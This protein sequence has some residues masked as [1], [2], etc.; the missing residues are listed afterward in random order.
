MSVALLLKQLLHL[1]K[2]LTMTHLIRKANIADVERI[3]SLY[4]KVGRNEG[5]LARTEPEITETYVASFVNNARESGLQLLVEKPDRSGQIIGEVHCYALGPK[6]FKHVLGELTIAIDPDFQG[7]G[8]GRLLFQNLLE[9][10]R[11]ERR[12]ILRVELI[13]RESNMKAIQFYKSLGFVAEGR[14]ENRISSKNGKK[15]ADIP[16]AWFNPNYTA[17]S[18]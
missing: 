18:E 4:R 9:M 5:G 13:A 2:A 12:D 11:Q 6:V 14:F 10:V 17:N 15:E 7:E 3:L 1:A 8:L 16:M